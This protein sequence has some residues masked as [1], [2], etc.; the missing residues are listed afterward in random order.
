MRILVSGGTGFIG[1]H[2]CVSLLQKGYEL[3]IVDNFINSNICVV[4]KIKKIAEK[5]F[6]FFNIDIT[7]KKDLSNIFNKTKIDAVIHFAAIKSVNESINKP[8]EYYYNNLVSTL[9]LI[10]LSV[11]NGIKKFVFSSSATVYGDSD[12]PCKED[13]MLRDATNPYG[14]TKKICEK[15]LIDTSKVFKNISIDILRYFNPI[16]AH[17]SGEIGENPNDIPN[18][19]M[20]FILDVAKGKREKLLIYGDDYPTVDGTGVR[21]YIHVMDIAE[22]HI[23]ALENTHEGYE[24]YNLGTGKGTSVL[25]LVN[26]FEEVNNISIPYEIVDRR[27]GDI[28]FSCA[29]V[30]KAKKE[31][32]WIAKMSVED[33]LRD[34]WNYTLK[35]NDK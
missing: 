19:L 17:K 32:K 5:N 6:D 30:D 28:A 20:P 34:A 27:S 11:K 12:L 25:E 23:A 9:N 29:N 1:S 14:E 7:N 18:N 16:G 15:I 31:L 8:V 3:V 4:D 10:D 21:D 35:Y 26:K 33:M 13:T 22:G 24:I 2:T